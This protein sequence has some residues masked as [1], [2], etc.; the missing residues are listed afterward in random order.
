MIWGWIAID[1]LS[2]TDG[3]YHSSHR[4]Q[5]FTASCVSRSKKYFLHH[6]TRRL[7]PK[8]DTM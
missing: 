2:S 7:P 8:S 6:E 3:I 5:P 1:I 4:E